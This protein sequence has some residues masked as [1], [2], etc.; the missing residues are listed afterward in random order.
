MAGRTFYIYC[1]TAPNGKRY[2]G[3]TC[4]NKPERRWGRGYKNCHRIE[5]AIEKYGWENFEHSVLM[6]CHSKQMADLL[7]VNLIAFFDTT[8]PNRGYNIL[9]GGGGR[10]DFSP[11][12]ETRRKISK[13]LTGRKGRIPSAEVR[14]RMS[15][16]QKKAYANGSKRR[17]NELPEKSQDRIRGAL[18]REAAKKRRSVVQ[19]DLDGNQV[20]VYPSV[21]EACRA[22][23]TFQSGLILC[24]QGTRKKANGFTWRYQDKPETFPSPIKGLFS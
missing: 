13:S 21:A 24:C 22:T 23:G 5:H 19:F 14:R 15:E 1:H 16:A 2:I 12:E 20:A 6:I 10:I 18:R 9:M 7:E 3:Q 11:S 17:F 4:A 8:N